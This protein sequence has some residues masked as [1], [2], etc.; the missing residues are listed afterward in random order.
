[1]RGQRRFLELQAKGAD[2]GLARTIAEVKERDHVDSNRATSPLKQAE[3]AVVIDTSE[4]DIPQVL[5]RMLAV[6]AERRDNGEG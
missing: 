2:V 1:M 3:D 4:L 6:V 5:Q